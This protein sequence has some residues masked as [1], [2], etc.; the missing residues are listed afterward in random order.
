VLEFLSGAH[1]AR[2]FRD[3]HPTYALQLLAH[4]DPTLAQSWSNLLRLT[5]E[6]LAETMLTLDAFDDSLF[7]KPLSRANVSFAVVSG[8]L[9]PSL[10]CPSRNTHTTN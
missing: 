3:S 4:A 10:L 1:E 2:A 6:E 8:C 9:P 7:D 5:N